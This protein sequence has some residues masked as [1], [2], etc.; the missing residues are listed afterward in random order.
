MYSRSNASDDHG[1]Y[2]RTSQNQFSK[3]ISALYDSDN[4]VELR[5]I[6]TWTDPRTG[7]R[8]SR[9]LRDYHWWLTPG[10]LRSA[11]SELAALNRKQWANIFVGVNPR[12]RSGATK[13]RDIRLCRSIWADID[14]VSISD[15]T[16]RWSA[17][18]L[19]SPSIVVQSGSGAHLYWLLDTPH[20]L[21][22]N[23]DRRI[24]ELMLQ[25]LYRDLR[26][27]AIHDMGR[28]L[29]LPGFLNMKE[30]RN[31]RTPVPCKLIECDPR[32]RYSISVFDRWIVLARSR[33][34]KKL[35]DPQLVSDHS[36]LDR[37]GGFDHALVRR[38][39]DRLQEKVDDRSRRDYA[40]VCGLLRLGM[41]DNEIWRL[42]RRQSKFRVRGYSYFE[43]TIEN[44]KRDVHDPLR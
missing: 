9:L 28:L 37:P 32:R 25:A 10:E 16:D 4:L 12:E 18:E 42:V 44:A 8:R 38:A 36:R 35:V 6:E 13:K 17:L 41:T 34:Y 39:L 3:F 11:Y 33:A 22:D 19:P 26:S 5:P 23:E 15:A 30:A 7:N 24:F 29:R 40:V 2:F 20:E 14:R 31:G 43:S 21:K 1:A 27:D